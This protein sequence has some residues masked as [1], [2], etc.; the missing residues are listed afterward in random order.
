MLGAFL[1]ILLSF[2]SSAQSVE[3][4]GKD[5]VAVIP[6]DTLRKANVRLVE[7]M[8]CRETKD[9]LVSQVGTFTSLVASQRSTIT[10]LNEAI[11]LD[12]LLIAD[13]QKIIDLSDKELKKN[14]RKIKL[15]KLERAGLIGAVAVLVVKILI[16]K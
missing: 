6:I 14:A 1:P 7:F 4:R 3:V 10:D 11:R 15:L 8:E 13:K 2:S 16:A 12:A 5:T 9:S